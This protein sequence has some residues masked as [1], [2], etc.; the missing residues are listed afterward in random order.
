MR[1]QGSS[2]STSGLSFKV[3]RSFEFGG[4]KAERLSRAKG[5]DFVKSPLPLLALPDPDASLNRKIN[6]LGSRRCFHSVVGPLTFRLTYMQASQWLPH[7]ESLQ[8]Q[9]QS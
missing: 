2:H 8:S 7:A 3:L 4:V 5:F 9:A 6:S 1:Y